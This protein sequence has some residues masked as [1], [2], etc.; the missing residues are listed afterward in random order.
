[1]EHLNYIPVPQNRGRF[2]RDII[3]A[4]ITN[5]N[6]ATLC[7]RTNEATCGLQVTWDSLHDGTPYGRICPKCRE[8][9][10]LSLRPTATFW[11]MDPYNGDIRSFGSITS[12]K[13]DARKR[14]GSSTIWQL[15][16]GEINRI[17]ETVN[18]LPA[19]P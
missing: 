8:K 14:N 10:I 13:R 15:G 2:G 5:G 19:L 3:N 9:A 4:H 17:V 12:A 1:M 6:G 18:G 7:G 16:P 11:F